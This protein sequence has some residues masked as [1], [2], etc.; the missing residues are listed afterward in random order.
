MTVPGMHVHG[1][2][3]SNGKR[4]LY[5]VWHNKVLIGDGAGTR[6]WFRPHRV[7]AGMPRR[8]IKEKE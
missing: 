7:S 4:R 2:F 8:P 5:W 3:F 1:L 6:K